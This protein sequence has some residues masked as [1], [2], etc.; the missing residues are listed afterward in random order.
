MVDENRGLTE[1]DALTQLAFVLQGTLERRA[2]EAELTLAQTRLLGIL[3]DRRPSMS[4]LAQFLGLDKSSTTGLVDRAERRGL[5]ERAASG[6]DR[7]VVQ[8]R[9]T[10]TGR[11]LTTRVGRRYEA[12]VEHLLSGLT[13]AQRA[14][15]TSLAARVLSDDAAARGISLAPAA[16][17]PAPPDRT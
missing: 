8:V 1:V 2:A 3:R 10:R 12:D 11:A 9:L 16:T 4:E 15:F 7:R 14:T 6:T 13:A 5:V 17:N